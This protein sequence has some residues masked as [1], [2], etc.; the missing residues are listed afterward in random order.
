MHLHFKF[1]ENPAYFLKS[2]KNYF[3]STNL[4]LGKNYNQLGN[5]DFASIEHV[6]FQ[7]PAFK[8]N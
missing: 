7:N 6:K 2:Q 1:H 4:K 3:K 5:I 8:S